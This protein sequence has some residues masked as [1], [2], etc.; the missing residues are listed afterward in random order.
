MDFQRNSVKEL[1]TDYVKPPSR[2][3]QNN[4]FD[5]IDSLAKRTRSSMCKSTTI[6]NASNVICLHKNCWCVRKKN[7]T[8][9][10]NKCGVTLFIPLENIIY[11]K[12]ICW[13][14]KFW[15]LQV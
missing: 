2:P 13:K 15:T 7:I 10:Q 11:K 1:V 14:K 9:I 4:R 3:N 8:Y 12:V 6:K 5:P